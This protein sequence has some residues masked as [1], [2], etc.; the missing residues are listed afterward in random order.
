MGKYEFEHP[1]LKIN[2]MSFVPLAGVHYK[3]DYQ[4]IAY[5]I[6]L[7]ELPEIDTYRSLLLKDLWFF[8]YFALQIPVANHPFWVDVCQEV[9]KLPT[10]NI[11]YLWAREHGKSTILTTAQMAQKI[12]KHQEK[13]M[14]IFSYSKSAAAKLLRPLKFLFEESEFLKTCFPDVLYTNPSGDA[15]MWTNENIVVKRNGYYREGSIE[16]HGLIEGMPTGSHFTDRH[17]DDI[18]TLDLVNTPEL[19]RKC[20]EAYDMSQSLG[21][22]MGEHNIC[23][24]PY[25]HQGVLMYLMSKRSAKNRLL[26]KTH[27]KPALDDGT[28][29]GN[30]VWLTDDRIDELK[31]NRRQFF[32]QYLLDPTPVG[33]G[34]LNP[35]FLIQVTPD[36]VP[37]N[38]VKF[39]LVDPA[40][41]SKNSRD[42]DSWAILT[43]GVEPNIDDMGTSNIFII[44]A[45]IEPMDLSRGTNAVVAMYCRNGRVE[46]LAVE[47]ASQSTFATHLANALRAKNKFVTE[48]NGRLVKIRHKG[49]NKVEKILNALVWPLNN[50][51][52]HLSSSIPQ[53]CR[54]R[55]SIEFRKFPFF[56]HDDF[57]DALSF[58]Y[59]LLED[60]KFNKKPLTQEKS[61]EK[62]ENFWD[63]LR[64]KKTTPD[65]DWMTV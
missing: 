51:K 23:G 59:D 8:V 64:R 50:G 3:Y 27:L 22:N 9:E 25:H 63:K 43:V 41:A 33:E 48:E 20:I 57:P 44:D 29:N 14:A 45:I 12:L 4:Q 31:G 32:S 39:M 10:T 49:R 21:T 28:P 54:D 37:A 46:I 61:L 7:G 47:D 24:T 40:L 18:E 19:M 26:Y 35:D 16:A 36:D 42:A 53:Q 11:L 30:P 58:L 5:K 62:R 2:K 6:A 1:P 17:Y 55:M 52:I 65:I 56:A 38:I 60:Y 34:E 13:R 15:P